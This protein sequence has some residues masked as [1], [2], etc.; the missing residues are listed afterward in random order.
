MENKEK[1]Y[2][3]SRLDC[4]ET[5]RYSYF[6]NYILSKEKLAEMGLVKK[7]NIYSFLGGKTHEIIED[8]QQD[9]IDNESAVRIFKDAVEEADF[10]GHEWISGKVKDNYCDSI[11]HYLENW[12]KIPGEC[13]LEK[14]FLIDIDGIKIKGFID[15]LSKQGN[16]VDIFDYKTSS[17]FAKRD[18]PTYGRQLV[19]YALAVQQIYPEVEIRTIAWHMLKYAKV[20]RKVE[21]RADVDLLADFEPFVQEYLYNEETI[22]D[23]KDYVKSRVAEIESLG[24]NEENFPPKV[25]FFFCKKLCDFGDGC[26]YFNS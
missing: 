7:D 15:I 9:K 2:S 26:K 1:V 25:D 6:L 16:I 8:L 12:E 10:L 20:G 11:V 21:L 13:E 22:K 23:L 18:L 24:E 5:C 4:F 17:K 14:E 19:L 3:Y